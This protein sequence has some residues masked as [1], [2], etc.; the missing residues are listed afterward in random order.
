MLKKA[1]FQT[2]WCSSACLTSKN[3]HKL[4]YIKK[5]LNLTMIKALDFFLNN[6]ERIILQKKT[7]QVS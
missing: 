2:L 7:G 3:H 5:K 4:N 1:F 6:N